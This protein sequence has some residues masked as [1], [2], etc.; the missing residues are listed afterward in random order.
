MSIFRLFP[1][2]GQKL[3]G[4]FAA[5]VAVLVAPK[6]TG[7]VIGLGLYLIFCRLLAIQREL[8]KS[9]AAEINY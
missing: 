7:Q 5:D 2:G 1:V 9:P 8:F 6:V 3:L 4:A